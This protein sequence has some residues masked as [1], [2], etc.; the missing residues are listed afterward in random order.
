MTGPISTAERYG[1]PVV[2]AP[3]DVSEVFASPCSQLLSAADLHV[4][5]ISGQGRPRSYLGSNQC[6]WTTEDD[7][8]LSVAVDNDRDLLVDTYRARL[9]PIFV[10]TSIEGLP[11]V[12]QL[13][14]LRYNVC[15][16]V[17][18]LGPRQALE[19]DWNGLAPPSEAPD[20]CSRAERALSLVI[21][22]LPP[23][24]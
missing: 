8:L 6:A 15:T 20:P 18:G 24:K 4:L 14:S 13:T 22:K 1:A 3:R 21:R 12:R 5:R 23:Q 11:A 10:P 9:S 16:V 7:D 19:A 17:V 2:T